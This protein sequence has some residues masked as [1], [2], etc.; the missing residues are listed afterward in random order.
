MTTAC[1][2][3]QGAELP[4]LLVQFLANDGTTVI[5][6]TG[7]TCVLK[8]AAD[9]STTPV[10]TKSSG[11]TATATGATVNFAAGELDVPSGQY[12]F[13]LTATSGGLDYRRQGSITILPK[14]A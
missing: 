14:L 4:P 7:F 8:I 12:L 13:E 5:D 9:T 6:L 3:V 11:I 10:L 2:Y 1:E